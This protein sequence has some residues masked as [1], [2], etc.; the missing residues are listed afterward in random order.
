M[1]RRP[2]RGEM[3]VPDERGLKHQMICAPVVVLSRSGEMNAPDERGLKRWD[4]PSVV[5]PFMCHGDD[6]SAPREGIDDVP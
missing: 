3:N 5:T 1:D 2:S 6:A 4:S